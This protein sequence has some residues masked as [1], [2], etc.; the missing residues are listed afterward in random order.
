MSDDTLVCKMMLAVL[1]VSKFERDGLGDDARKH[2]VLEESHIVEGLEMLIHRNGQDDQELLARIANLAVGNVLT[3]RLSS[4]HR[5]VLYRAALE[6][7]ENANARFLMPFESDENASARF[8]MGLLLSSA[9]RQQGKDS[10]AEEHLTR[11]LVALEY[12]NTTGAMSRVKAMLQIVLLGTPEDS[13]RNIGAI[14]PVLEGDG[15]LGKDHRS[16]LSLRSYLAKRVQD[17]GRFAEAAALYRDALERKR[18]ALGQDD[19]DT[20][21]TSNSL[22]DCLL[23]LN[24]FEEACVLIKAVLPD[25]KKVFGENHR[26]YLIQLETLAESLIGLERFGEAKK[27]LDRVLQKQTEVLGA[28]N[29]QTRDTEDLL[30]SLADKIRDVPVIP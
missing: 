6:R 9:L 12:G 15:G 11:A 28:D 26:T 23:K 29:K 24:K 3:T 4:A 21:I 10:E 19:R 8:Q 1:T 25:S 30:V 13:E 27:I 2:F 18:A 14:L 16:A 7:N 22:A 20:L 5:E 17:Q